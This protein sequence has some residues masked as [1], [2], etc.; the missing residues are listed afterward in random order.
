MSNSVRPHRQQPTRLPCPWDSPGKNTGMGFR[1]LLQCMKVKSESEVAQSCL[2]PTPWTAAYQA[3]PSMAFSRHHRHLVNPNLVEQCCI[4]ATELRF[5]CSSF[6][7]LIPK[8]RCWIKGQ[9]ALL[10]KPETLGR[11]W[12]HVPKGQLITPH[13]CLEIIQGK[14]ERAAC[15]GYMSPIFRDNHLD[16]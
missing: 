13:V 4:C 6:K 8:Y 12:S 11:R 2:T 5:S 7:N 9:I 1:C 14:A 16:N 15:W 3:P 10:R